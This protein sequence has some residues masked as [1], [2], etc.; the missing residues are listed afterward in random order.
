MDEI[1]LDLHNYPENAERHERTAV[2]G[3]V[4][5]GGRYLMIYSRKHGDCK[6]PG[7]GRETGETLA[8]TLFREMRE[9]T[10]YDVLPESLRE[11][12]T[13]HERRVSIHGD[14]LCMD[15]HYYFCEVGDTVHGQQ[16]Q[17]YE[18]DEDYEVRWLTLSEA[19]CC[20]RAVDQADSTPWIQREIT[21]LE[22]L[23]ESES[24]F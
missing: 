4:R 3:I 1:T 18:I 8:D 20:N 10:G 5:R 16:L 13:V 15:S 19:L 7:G 2:R 17:D 22:R 11:Y 12:L 14:L 9:E 21:V 23:T 24:S 6:F